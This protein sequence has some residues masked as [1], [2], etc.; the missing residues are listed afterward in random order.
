MKF[1]NVINQHK[2]RERYGMLE[3][4]LLEKGFQK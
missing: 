2:I 4:N 1:D 3:I